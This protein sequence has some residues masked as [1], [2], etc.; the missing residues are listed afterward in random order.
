MNPVAANWAKSQLGRTLSGRWVLERLIGLGGSAAVFEAAHRNGKRVAIKLLRP[1]RAADERG[2]ARF[3]R[4]GYAANRVAHPRVVSVDDDGQEADGSAFLVMEL[5]AG[6]SV[7]ALAARWGGKL[8][9]PQVCTLTVQLLEVLVTA[10]QR[11]VIHRDI[12]PANLF[13]SD[14]GGLR[15][16]D[17]GLAQ[18]P[19]VD[20]GLVTQDGALLGTPAYMAP[21]Q[22]RAANRGVNELSDLWAVGATAFSLLTGRK[23]YEAASVED[24]LALAA[25]SPAPS[26]LLLAPEAPPAVVAVLQRA[27][28]YEPARRWPTAAAM[29]GALTAALSGE[30]QRAEPISGEATV[31][32]VRRESD[33]DGSIGPTSSGRSKRSS[34][35]RGIGALLFVCA[36]G[37]GVLLWRR[38]PPAPEPE[39]EPAT[40]ASQPD[41]PLESTDARVFSPTAAPAS[42]SAEPAPRALPPAP[43]ERAAPRRQRP[44]VARGGGGSLIEEPPF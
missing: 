3:L 13:W 34:R 6:E 42:P 24:Q 38:S 7:D 4:E 43:T 28:E 32:S 14:I 36:A 1:E 27:L 26:L 35:S 21:E 20:D 37:L 40:D 23:V 33:S 15:V 12:K 22:A 8:P 11:G 31:T 25:V 2:R 44:G 17:F 5:L 16:L 19:S 29:L 9:W 10:H 41:A 18:L 30:A 39:P